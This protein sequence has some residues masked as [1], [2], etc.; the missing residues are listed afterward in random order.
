MADNIVA[1]QSRDGALRGPADYTAVQPS[2]HYALSSAFLGVPGGRLA[3]TLH[4]FAAV[5][6]MHRPHLSE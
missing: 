3:L 1:T 2:V 5:E 4:I 6:K